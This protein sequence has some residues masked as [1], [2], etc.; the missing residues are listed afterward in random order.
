MRISACFKINGLDHLISVNGINAI[1]DVALAG[2]TSYYL[3]LTDVCGNQLTA[4]ISI[5]RVFNN[6][7]I[8]D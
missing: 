3:D 2:G 4:S 6:I 5:E 8:I 1:R 7:P